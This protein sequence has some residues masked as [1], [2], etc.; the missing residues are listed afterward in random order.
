MPRH[1]VRGLDLVAAA[2]NHR[3]LHRV[4]ELANVA[5]PGVGE[6]PLPSCVVEAAHRLAILLGESRQELICQ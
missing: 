6:D 1:D 5:R 2:H 3:P 4:L